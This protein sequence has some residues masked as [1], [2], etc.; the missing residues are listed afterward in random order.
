VRRRWRVLLEAR[1]GPEEHVAEQRRGRSSAGRPSPYRSPAVLGACSVAFAAHVGDRNE[2]S[3]PGQAER[4]AAPRFEYAALMT[5]WRPFEASGGHSRCVERL[6]RGDGT[7]ARP[8]WDGH[9][10]RASRS[11]GDA[12][13]RQAV[14]A[15]VRAADAPAHF[16]NVNAATTRSARRSSNGRASS[17]AGGPCGSSCTRSRSNPEGVRRCGA[18]AADHQGAARDDARRHGAQP[19]LLGTGSP[20]ARL[21]GDGTRVFA[22]TSSGGSRVMPF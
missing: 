1:P 17:R 3:P 11:Q 5:G 18:H 10:R 4:A 13:A 22:M 9:R 6:R 15:D 12:A 8:P 2:A 19:G 16:F 14:A 7:G 21:V 20:R